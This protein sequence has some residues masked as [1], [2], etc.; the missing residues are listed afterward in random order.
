MNVVE[1]ARLRII[2]GSLARSTTFSFSI[3]SSFFAFVLDFAIR[4]GS[5]A[6]RTRADSHALNTTSAGKESSVAS[7]RPDST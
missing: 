3:G 2:Q 4:V 6:E 1:V 7:S 5:V